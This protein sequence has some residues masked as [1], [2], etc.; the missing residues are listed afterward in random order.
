MNQDFLGHGWSFPSTFVRDRAAVSMLEEEADIASS[1]EI[2]LSTTPGEGCTV[3]AWAKS[4][5]SGVS[6]RVGTPSTASTLSGTYRPPPMLSG[7]G[8]VAGTV[9][10][11]C[12]S[13]RP[14]AKVRVRP[15]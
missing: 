13:Q 11:F 7:T 5:T 1:L 9:A 10:M 12:A 8:R 2:L 14:P 15:P 4:S 6:A 3:P